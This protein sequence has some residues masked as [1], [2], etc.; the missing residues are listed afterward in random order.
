MGILQSCTKSSSCDASI[1]YHKNVICV[2]SLNWKRRTLM[3][4]I[5][6]SFDVLFE[7]WL[8]RRLNRQFSCRRYET[9]WRPCN[10]S[11]VTLL[12]VYLL[13][14]KVNVNL[15]YLNVNV[16]FNNGFGDA[17]YLFSIILFY[18]IWNIYLF[19]YSLFGGGWGWGL[20]LMINQHWLRQ[21]FF[22]H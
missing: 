8:R 22:L 9:P 7:A 4:F 14:N 20:V 11:V 16:I 10:V 17:R 18:L 2:I 1:S 13:V 21:T 5:V 15:V 3:L 6:R 12:T 19:I